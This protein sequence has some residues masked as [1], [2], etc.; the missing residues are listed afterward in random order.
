MQARTHHRI[1]R[2]TQRAPGDLVVQKR[3]IGLGRLQ[4]RLGPGNV[5]GPRARL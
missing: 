3:Q 1:A 2:C 4:Q 5:L